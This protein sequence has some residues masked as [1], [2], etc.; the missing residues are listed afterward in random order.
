MQELRV[1][2]LFFQ[3]V[4]DT[5]NIVTREIPLDDA[6]GFRRVTIVPLICPE[7]QVAR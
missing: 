6:G 5:E 4:V 2:N 1:L 3:Y 7:L